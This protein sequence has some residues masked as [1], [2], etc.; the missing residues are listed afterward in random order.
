MGKK[1]RERNGNG[2]GKHFNAFRK[3]RKLAL[4]CSM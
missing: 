1:E 3:K 2:N 4:A